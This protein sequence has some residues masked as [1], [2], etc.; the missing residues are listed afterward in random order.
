MPDSVFYVE[1]DPDDRALFE[2]AVSLCRCSVKFRL[3][4]QSRIAAD[5]LLGKGVYADRKS[6]PIPRL[7]VTDIRMPL[8]DG[9]DLMKLVRGSEATR[10]LPIIAVSSSNEEIDKRRAAELGVE[11][12]L[13][14]SADYAALIR[15][16]R[17]F[18]CTVPEQFC[19]K[20][21]APE[22]CR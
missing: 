19:T 20:R 21:R 2:R 7:L 1:D 3:F 15:A 4:D 8:I 5:Y 14:K 13:T 11:L 6:Y 16:V 22:I 18:A 10:N 9:F 17:P 12:F